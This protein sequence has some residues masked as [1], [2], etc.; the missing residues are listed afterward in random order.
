MATALSAQLAQIRAKSVYPS[1]VKAQ[2]KAHG[3]SLLFDAKVAASQDF[4][5]IFEIC[6]EGFED[7]C[8]IDSRF[9]KFTKNIFS[10]QSKEEDRTQMTVA[11]ENQLNGVLED[12]LRLVGAR[13]QL[14]PAA[15]AVEWLVRRFRFVFGTTYN[16][17]FTDWR[18]QSA[19]AQHSLLRFDI[20]P[21]LFDPYVY[22][23]AIDTPTR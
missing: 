11:Q 5:T 17:P 15:K 7:L 10:E 4:E 12:F 16:R 3:K 20:P 13:A 2:K 6:V 14:N 8:Q 23:R 9:K 1:D 18:H 21:L 22:E 19:R